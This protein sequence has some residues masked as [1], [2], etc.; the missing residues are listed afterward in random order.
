MLRV[1][2]Q[3][4]WLRPEF[5]SARDYWDRNLEYNP[6]RG[7]AETSVGAMIA[8]L[9]EAAGDVL[10]EYA[11]DFRA[12][13]YISEKIMRLKRNLN[14]PANFQGELSEQD[15]A[16]V[17]QILPVLE[18]LPVPSQEIGQIKRLITHLLKRELDQ[19]VSVHQQLYDRLN[20]Q[21]LLL[22]DD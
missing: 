10:R 6:L 7:K 14:N 12:P 2:S 17:A 18:G 22:T 3:R 1:I 8:W 13:G 19:A 15:S 20:E 5:E 11:Q 16:A 21:R 9:M 4:Q